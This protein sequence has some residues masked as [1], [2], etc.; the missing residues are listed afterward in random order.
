MDRPPPQFAAKAG[1][2]HLLI[3]HR[4]FGPVPVP[5]DHVASRDHERGRTRSLAFGEGTRDPCQRPRRPEPRRCSPDQRRLFPKRGGRRRRDRPC[6]P[7]ASGCRANPIPVRARRAAPPIGTAR[8]RRRAARRSLPD[9]R[10]SRRRRD[11]RARGGRSRP[12][13]RRRRSGRRGVLRSRR[14]PPS[15]HRASTRRCRSSAAAQTC[16]TEPSPRLEARPDRPAPYRG[17]RS[18]R[19]GS[20]RPRPLLRPPIARD[21][22]DRPHSA[23]APVSRTCSG[24]RIGP[25][26]ARDVVI[27]PDKLGKDGGADQARRTKEKDVHGLLWLRL[28]AER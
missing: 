19:R 22:V 2:G 11:G 9:G 16:R 15:R 21:R 26:K 20:P 17:R 6:G 14:S 3:Q 5:C 7:G 28:S 4:S 18:Q 13:R 1:G 23:S 24:R 12:S 25:G 8:I 27:V 10:C